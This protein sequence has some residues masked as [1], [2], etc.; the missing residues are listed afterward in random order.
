MKEQPVLSARVKCDRQTGELLKEGAAPSWA[1]QRQGYAGSTGFSQ[2]PPSQ[3]PLP[4]FPTPSGPSPSHA[5]HLPVATKC[6]ELQDAVRCLL[7]SAQRGDRRVTA[8]ASCDSE[9]PVSPEDP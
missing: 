6:A 1:L 5:G 4:H 2:P 9:A 8:T 3:H 7:E